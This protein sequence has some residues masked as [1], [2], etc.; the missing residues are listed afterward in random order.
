MAAAALMLVPPIVA[1][2]TAAAA[3]PT[4]LV[5][6]QPTGPHAVGRDVLHL[7]D[8]DRRDP[9]VPE[10]KARELMVS[11]FYPARRAAG[12]TAPYLTMTEARLFLE[13][14]GL[15]GV[16][17]AGELSATRTTAHPGARPLRGRYPLVVLSPGLSVHRHT[18]THLA[19]ELASRGYVVAAVDHAYESVGTAFPGG[20]VLTCVACDI[21]AGPGDDSPWLVTGRAQDVAFV[22]DRLTGPRP[23]WRHT[24]L[25]DRTRIGMAGH[26][27]GGASAAATMAVDPRV[28]AGINM[29]GTFFAPVPVDGLGGRPFMMLGA[30]PGHLPGS[31]GDPSWDRDWRRLDGWKR[32]LTVTGTAHIDFSDLSV[33]ADQAG[34]VDPDSPLPGDRTA[35]IMRGYVTAFFDLHLRGTAQPLLDGPTPDNPEVVFHRP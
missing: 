34:L 10:A 25:I 11:M 14:R 26:S 9:W 32:W 12:R 17:S 3:P 27:I 18:L 4:R 7:V 13:S 5:L 2:D 6:P 16:L 22:L 15:T 35:E 30:P 24:D 23:A 31:T 29:D 8:R 28:L 19:E 33:L 21:L 1:A 20:R